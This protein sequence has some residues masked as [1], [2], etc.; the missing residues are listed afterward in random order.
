[1]ESNKFQWKENTAQLQSFCCSMHWM[2]QYCMM[3]HEGVQLL[4]SRMYLQD[5]WEL[6]NLQIMY[7][8]SAAADNSNGLDISNE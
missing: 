6:S 2:Q 5:N 4:T 7:A 1:M 8:P 3:D